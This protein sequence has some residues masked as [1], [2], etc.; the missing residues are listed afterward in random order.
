ME[1][2]PVVGLTAMPK[3][4]NRSRLPVHDTPPSHTPPKWITGVAAACVNVLPTVAALRFWAKNTCHVAD[5]GE[6]SGAVAPSKNAVPY[7]TTFSWPGSQATLH[8][9]TA[10]A[11]GAWFTRIGPVHVENGR[12]SCRGR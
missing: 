11:E 2:R 3:S 6:L 9:M 5:G 1:A 12:A 8:G 4:S 7:H 10:V